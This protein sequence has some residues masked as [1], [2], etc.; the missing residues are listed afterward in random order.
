MTIERPIVAISE[1]T[2]GRCFL[3]NGVSATRCITTPII[4]AATSDTTAHTHIGRPHSA[5]SI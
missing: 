1:Y 5:A 3:A 2:S 4:P